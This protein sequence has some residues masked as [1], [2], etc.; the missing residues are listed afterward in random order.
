[1]RF[2]PAIIMASLALASCG[3]P[4][5]AEKAEPANAA[6]NAGGV[7]YVAAVAALPPGQRNGVFLR[8]VRDAGLPCQKI[9][10]A[11]PLESKTANGEWK[12]QCDS[13]DMHLISIP[14]SGQAIVTSRTD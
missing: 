12:V 8:A 2:L 7:D 10:S 4:E 3:S 1:M 5:T 9:A 11:E 14:P 13:G 6:A